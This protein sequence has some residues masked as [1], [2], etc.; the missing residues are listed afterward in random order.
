VVA[1][2][3]AGVA[4]TNHDSQPSK[5][6]DSSSSDIPPRHGISTN[7]KQEEGELPFV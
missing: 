1:P 3:V 4:Y 7:R 2:K 6:K 5:L